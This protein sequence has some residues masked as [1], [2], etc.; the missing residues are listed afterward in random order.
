[1]RRSGSRR[2]LIGTAR[3]RVALLALLLIGLLTACGRDG[4]VAGGP[5]ELS[6]AEATS[7]TSVRVVF[8]GP[9][10]ADVAQAGNYLVTGA[11]GRLDVVAA[12]L[13]EDPG[14]VLL[15]T[16]PQQPAAE[17]RL[18]V[19]GASAPDDVAQSGTA[20]LTFLGSAQSA[21]V[22]A[23]AV[24]LNNTSVLL[25]FVEPDTH[26]P[27]TLRNT[28]QN[29][30]YYVIEPH[31]PVVSAK[32][33]YPNF[34]ILTT[35]PHE[36]REYTVTAT[37]IEDTSGRLIDYSRASGSF[38]GLPSDDAQPPRITSAIALTDQAVQVSFS[39]PVRDSAADIASYAITDPA[40][41]MLVVRE[42]TLNRP[43]NTVAMLTTRPQTTGETYMLQASGL[44]DLNGNM[45]TQSGGRT[46]FEGIGHVQEGP[47]QLLS[48]GA[49]S[50]RS[51]LL[52]FT[53]ALDEGDVA[54]ITN[55]AIST[56][57]GGSVLS[58]L[59][60]ALVTPN[61]V[62]LTTR[63]QSALRYQVEVI[64][65]RDQ[66]G[67]QLLPSGDG[68]SASAVFLGIAPG[69]GDLVDSDG[70]GLSDAEEE[71][72]WTVTITLANG[73][74]EQYHVTSDPN[75]PDTD[76]DGVGD[77]EEKRYRLDPR[78]ADTD[79]DGLSDFQELHFFRTNPLLQD[80]DGDGLIDGVEVHLFGT[81]PVHAD[82][83]GDQFLDGDEVR[84]A[85]RNP[86]L[87][88]LPRISIEVGDVHLALDE[89]YS[90]T[91]TEGN[92]Q[93]VET[94][95]STTLE[96]GTERSHAKS[97][98]ST[99]A[100]SLSFNESL[101]VG[102]EYN[103]PGFSVSA[104]VTVG[105]EQSQSDEY[106]S[107]VSEESAVRSNQAYNE[108]VARG[109]TFETSSSVTREVHGAAMQLTLNLGSISDVPF[110]VTNLEISALWQDPIDPSRLVPIASLVPGVQLVSGDAPVYNL[111][112]FVPT[113]GPLVFDNRN[114]FPKTLEEL[115]RSPRGLVF[116]VANYDMQD[117]SGRNFAF[118][119]LDTYDRTA[120]LT[121]DYGDGTVD[122]HRIATS[123]FRLAP[124]ADTNGDGRIDLHC[125]IEN[126]D[127]CDNNGD[128]VVNEL[129]RISFNERGQPVGR[130]MK[131]AFEL[132]GIDYE[133]RDVDYDDQ[134]AEV[135]FRIGS[136]LNKADSHQAWVLFVSDR[137]GS[138]GRIVQVFDETDF[139]DIVLQPGASYQIAYLQD[140][141]EDQL[142]A[143]EEY[144]H[145]SRDDAINSDNHTD[146]N[147]LTCS[148][149]GSP[150]GLPDG[151]PFNY[152]Q[153]AGH[154][155]DLPL[156]RLAFNCDT[157]SDFEE[158]REGWLVRVRGE[159][160][161]RA[162]SSPRLADSDGD[163]IPD[164][165]E[166][167][168]GTD[169][170]KRDTDGDGI[171]DF[172]E[173][174]G[175]WM[176]FHDGD[177]FTAI[178]DKFCPAM[179][180]GGTC[181]AAD[182]AYYVTNPLDPDTDG[183][184]ILDGVELLIGS[185]PQLA[186]AAY[187]I[188]TDQDGLSDG[189]ELEFG[190]SIYKPDTDGDGLPD[191]LEYLI[192]SNPLVADTDGDGISDYHEL[193]IDTFGL[194]PGKDFDVLAFGEMCGSVVHNATAC[195]YT[196]PSGDGLGNRSLPYGT[197]PTDSDTDGDG[198]S[199]FE[200]LAVGWIVE[201]YSGDGG[202]YSVTSN[203]LVADE[204]GDG[205]NDSAEKAKKTDP[206]KYDTDGDGKNDRVDALPLRKDVNLSFT[207]VSIEMPGDC[208]GGTTST[209]D[210]RGPLKFQFP[211][212]TDT[213]VFNLESGYINNA[214]EKSTTSLP[215]NSIGFN[216][217][218]GESFRVL[219][220]PIYEQDAGIADDQLGSYSRTYSYGS[221]YPGTHA[222]DLKKDD[223][224]HLVLNWRIRVA[225]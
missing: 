124:F 224:C 190:T 75:N 142:F 65:I 119:S 110:S 193:N 30:Q 116:K 49:T 183:D 201:L 134:D 37:N 41:R 206:T 136:I 221:G 96:Q 120:G 74:I 12:Y 25:T 76:G 57:E 61:T 106:S 105:S 200:E 84:L 28:A 108:S 73:E 80:T 4:G 63:P 88:D 165:I 52:T 159:T 45:M 179:I 3:M 192:G 40:G 38:G 55:Y 189:L 69:A 17:Y 98:T 114:V 138:G 5:V 62:E 156:V 51:V 9:V 202:H 166:K 131:G 11:A 1:M 115:M 174:Y 197:D 177:G 181:A 97:D 92:T 212:G 146:G 155:G 169:P 171:S 143:H 58:V 22:L 70:D 79:D 196:P 167:L 8:T 203:P 101:T 86:L 18:A 81:S 151:Y 128:G 47:P 214:H 152:F 204:D 29:A 145:G 133:V 64:G 168:I 184:G 218:S 209:K 160:A 109:S 195:R 172:D 39:E 23:S 135:L 90:Y 176:R 154:S 178:V 87:A 54:V 162:Y 66:Q 95:S 99:L 46:T 59:E 89:R 127:E 36:D 71:R 213:T 132:L 164:H 43:Y 20:E 149:A 217:K 117:E 82:T 15:S 205:L 103:F 198:L 222:Q 31:L 170:M 67:N 10:G 7:G 44:A 121:I 161:Y 68:R 139:E 19:Q 13:S 188:D 85:G 163:G 207:Y 182:M 125:E 126:G 111:G 225:D 185:N 112:P 199:D 100:S 118:S 123:I 83:D 173:I 35:A 180:S 148:T 191:L 24:A 94:S 153:Q 104:E 93:S 187:F 137:P 210:F 102:G 147:S 2:A 186:D 53:K 141:D 223:G 194:L 77:L 175:F 21:P 130:T 6:R 14:V 48:A 211:N 140:S 27:V 129:D 113:I 26:R 78:A 158:V 56:L 144:L 216:L 219:G 60:A 33:A 122:R 220:G 50:N 42:V 16:A 34:V 215:S 32:M 157:L 91:N 107:T 208:E 150:H 72:G